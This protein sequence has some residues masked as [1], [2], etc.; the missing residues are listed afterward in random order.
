MLCKKVELDEVNRVM[1]ETKKKKLHY[2]RGRGKNERQ[3]QH[4]NLI[5]YHHHSKRKG[6]CKFKRN[7]EKSRKPHGSRFSDVIAL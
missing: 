1:E 7:K 4:W 5:M 3:T 6:H 2:I